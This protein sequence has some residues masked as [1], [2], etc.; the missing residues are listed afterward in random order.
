[1]YAGGEPPVAA[2]RPRTGLIDP[3]SKDEGFFYGQAVFPPSRP[4]PLTPM[5]V[6]SHC[7]LGHLDVPRIIS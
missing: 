3:S 6:D 5:L 2:P 4:S 7:H 1:L